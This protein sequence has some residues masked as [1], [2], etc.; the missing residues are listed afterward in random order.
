MAKGAEAST[1]RSDGVTAAACPGGR[2]FRRWSLE[3]RREEPRAAADGKWRSGVAFVAVIAVA[4]ARVALRPLVDGGDPRKACQ[5][6]VASISRL[7]QTPR[8]QG[9]RAER[10]AA[11]AVGSSLLSLG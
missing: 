8:A 1:A 11:A 6:C 5:G 2:H 7:A 10:S 3:R 4:R 9:A